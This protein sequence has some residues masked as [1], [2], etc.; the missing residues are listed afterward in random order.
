MT[1]TRRRFIQESLLGVMFFGAA[2]GRAC[3]QRA[4]TD[5]K[6]LARRRRRIIFNDDGDDVWHPDASTPEGFISVRLKHMLNT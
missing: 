6:A 4:P 1:T 5:R 2:S 3:A